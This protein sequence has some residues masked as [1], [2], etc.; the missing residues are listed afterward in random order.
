MR[1]AV[2]V[3]TRGLAHAG[4]LVKNGLVLRCEIEAVKGFVD[5]EDPRVR[6][7]SERAFHRQ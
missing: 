5:P 1:P 7:H 6:V 2:L 3:P 4:L